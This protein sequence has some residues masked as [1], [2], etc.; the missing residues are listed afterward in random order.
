MI[1]F[2]RNQLLLYF[3][4]LQIIFHSFFIFGCDLI[5]AYHHE[6]MLLIRFLQSL[7]HLFTIFYSTLIFYIEGFFVNFLLTHLIL[8]ILMLFAFKNSLS[9]LS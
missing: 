4:F 5:S 7:F 8:K 6:S 1:A 3:I 2:A 9:F